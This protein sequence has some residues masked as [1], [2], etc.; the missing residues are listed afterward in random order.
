MPVGEWL[1]NVWAIL[2]A[3]ATISGAIV[4]SAHAILYKRDTRATVLWVGFIWLAPVAG[5]ILYLLLGI[6][7]IKRRAELLRKSGPRHDPITYLGPDESLPPSAATRPNLARRV[8]LVDR[9]GPL[10]L[11]AGN[12]G[13]ALHNGDHAYP[14]ML[15]A[16]N[17]AQKTVSLC[18]YIFDRDSVGRQFVEALGAAAKRGVEVRVLIDATGARYSFPSIVHSLHRAGVKVARFL[19]TLAPFRTFALNMRNHRK[20]LVADGRVGFTG[21]INIRAGNCSTSAM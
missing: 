13:R 1:A 19:P 11:T 6:N 18:T 17:E 14:E 16:I 21:G 4:A 12:H 15:A 10:R 9:I 7:R 3:G 20:I 8:R 5:P 2:V